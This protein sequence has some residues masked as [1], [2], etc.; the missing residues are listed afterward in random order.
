MRAH[1]GH[2]PEGMLR[3]TA[4]SLL[5]AHSAL[6]Q[7]TLPADVSQL[8]LNSGFAIDG[9]GR[10]ARRPIN[11]DRVVAAM[12]MNPSAILNAKAGESL[13]DD[14]RESPS[15]WREIKAGE[16]GNFSDVKPGTYILVKITSPQDRSLLLNAA[17]H[18]MVYVNGTPRMGDPYGTGYVSLPITLRKGENT[19]LFAH[20]GR[21]GLRAALAPAP[22]GAKFIPS[23]I[24]LPDLKPDAVQEVH[25]GVP[26]INAGLRF[27]TI[28]VEAQSS[29]DK[30]NNWVR[31]GH[32]M[33]MKVPVKLKVQANASGEQ[34]VRLR[35][36]AAD[37]ELDKLELKL[38]TVA[39]G[40]YRR[41]FLSRI[42]S[43][44]Q[45][46]SVVPPPADAPVAQPAALVLSLHGAS[47]EATSQAGSYRQRPDTYIVCPTN[48]RP[49]GFDWEDWGRIDALEVM[50]LA[51]QMY[52]TDP[53]RQYLTGHSMGGHG[54]WQLGVHYPDRFAAIA[55]S[56]GWL[57]F[58]SYTSA[59]GPEFAPATP[60]GAVFQKARNASM[61]LDYFDNLK[62]KGIFILHGD[63]DDN[64]PVAQ[65]RA[66]REALDKAGIPYGFHE[67]PGAG[68][69]WGN[70]DSGAAC[71]DWPA[72]WETFSKSR[73]TPGSTA[74][75][76]S[77]LDD[78]GF[79]KGSFKRAFDRSFTLVYGT[80]GTYND[81]VLAYGK[82]RF[83]AEQWWVRGNGSARVMSDAR[84]IAELPPGN[85]I[86]YGNR[87]TNIAWRVLIAGDAL[88]IENDTLTVDGRTLQGKDI[89][90]LATFPRKGSSDD[91]VGVVGGTGLVGMRATERLNYFLSG[92]GYPELM[93]MRADIWSKGYDAVEA[94]S[95]GDG[96][97]VWRP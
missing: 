70:A 20:A 7:V 41:T 81:E 73:L 35:L 84:F 67:Q 66:G 44:V 40:P 12:V 75:V 18:A 93:I 37:L 72:I 58:D 46:F 69:W 85:V 48:R 88:V 97:I 91:L 77:P 3:F 2:Y 63:A 68:H 89:A 59:G 9:V 62:G 80:G 53:A 55:P 92:T 56:A 51:K 17:G 34:T 14:T 47:V 5:C 57:S 71:L 76:P 23:D 25:I 13:P 26:I 45:Y 43:S 11:T 94:A 50:D 90:C 49:F 64:V 38:Q 29:V 19:L 65:A 1:G 4:L 74:A 60:V 32:D 31:F 28:N 86:L 33:V 82:A 83:D 24:T 52:G 42:D 16:D 8:T 6:A 39:T 10:S 96:P 95:T 21:G 27:D 87:D 78:R 15:T 36:M 61:T 79:V 54:T 22:I 30:Q